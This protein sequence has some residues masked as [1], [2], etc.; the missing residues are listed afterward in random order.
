MLQRA[1]SETAEPKG[2]S[3]CWSIA[4]TTSPWRL[5]QTPPGRPGSG[6]P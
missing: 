1:A 3:F 4:P 5:V 2:C 6:A